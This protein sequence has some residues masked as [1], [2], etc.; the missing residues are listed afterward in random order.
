MPNREIVLDFIAQKKGHYCDD[1]ISDHTRVRPRQAV[2]QICRRLQAE[3][4]IIRKKDTCAGH[5]SHRLKLV[6]ILKR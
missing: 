3:G 2:N 5:C 4:I 1:C 6:N